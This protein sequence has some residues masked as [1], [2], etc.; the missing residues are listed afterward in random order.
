MLSM[1]Y[2]RASFFQPSMQRWLLSNSPRDFGKLNMNKNNRALYNTLPLNGILLNVLRTFD[3][4][5]VPILPKENFTV[6]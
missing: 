2:T 5:T 4:C 3:E 6:E 1:F